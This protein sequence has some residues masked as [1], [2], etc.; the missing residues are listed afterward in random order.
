MKVIGLQKIELNIIQKDHSTRA[1]TMQIVRN[2]KMLWYKRR[3]RVI[4]A[5]HLCVNSRGISDL[6]VYPNGEFK[7]NN[8]PEFSRL[9]S[10]LTEVLK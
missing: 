7:E 3:C 8:L 2:Y 1:L 6:S 4:D 10:N 5:K 9:Y